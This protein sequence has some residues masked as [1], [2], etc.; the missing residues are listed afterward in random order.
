MWLIHQFDSF[1]NLGTCKEYSIMAKAKT[2]RTNTGK[3]NGETLT[4][5]VN[6][7]NS[8]VTPEP[9]AEFREVRKAQ[10]DA[11]KNIV[12][13]NLEDEIR[14]RAYELWEQ[15]GRAAGHEN[16]HWLVAEREVRERYRAQHS[17][18]A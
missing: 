15:H 4:T 16:E 6:S 2:P 13:I 3:T 9:V 10:P 7:V 11:R 14:R 18:S 1:L 17:Q 5:P 12:P 8:S